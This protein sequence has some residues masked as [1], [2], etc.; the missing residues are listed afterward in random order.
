MCPRHLERFD[1]TQ[2][3]ATPWK[4]GGGATREIVRMPL[5]TDLESFDWRVS[6]AEIAADGEFSPFPGVDRV[7]V[8]LEGDGV[9]LDSADHRLDTPLVPFSF[10]GDE[11]ITARLLG[12]TS[13]D[14]NVMTRR[15]AVSAEVRIIRAT[16]MLAASSAGVLFVARGQWI[17][18]DDLL[19]PNSGVWWNDNPLRWSLTATSP[20][21]ALI[22]VSIHAR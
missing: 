5:G 9:Y 6:I 7:I 16:E 21:A 12:G 11:P 13:A 4:I 10:S 18:S 20:D 3:S 2:L 22:A 1:R 15:S 17:A 19:T 14:F 8:L